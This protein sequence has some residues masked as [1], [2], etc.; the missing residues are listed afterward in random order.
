VISDASDPSFSSRSKRLLFGVESA[1]RPAQW[2]PDDQAHQRSVSDCEPCLLKSVREDARKLCPLA[3]AT[4]VPE[5][6]PELTRGRAP[7]FL[8]LTVDNSSHTTSALRD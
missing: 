3:S 7:D 6:R 1:R 4:G 5:H 2:R 8:K